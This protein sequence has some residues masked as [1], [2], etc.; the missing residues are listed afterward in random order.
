MTG[1]LR[2]KVTRKLELNKTLF[3]VDPFSKVMLWRK[4]EN[5]M[6]LLVTRFPGKWKDGCEG[7][8]TD[9]KFALWL[10]LSFLLRIIVNFCT[11]VWERR[12]I[13]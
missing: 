10:F 4:Q 5:M 3:Y 8:I 2:V 1:N 13:D 11:C 7:A 12:T 9:W 6:L